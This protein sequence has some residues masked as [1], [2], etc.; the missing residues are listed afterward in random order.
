ME[1]KK[2][3]IAFAN[4]SRLMQK[5][6]LRWLVKPLYLSNRSKY[7]LFFGSIIQGKLLMRTVKLLKKLKAK[8]WRLSLKETSMKQ[9]SIRHQL[10]CTG[11][12]VSTS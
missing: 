6:S 7:K 11:T 1:G 4:F 5:R 8:P 2:T 9:L 10:S 12:A 3:R